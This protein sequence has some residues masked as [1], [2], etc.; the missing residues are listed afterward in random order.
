MQEVQA[1]WPGPNPSFGGVVVGEAYDPRQ[2]SR[3]IQPGQSDHMGPGRAGAAA[4]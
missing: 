3:A 4:D 2:A 1:L